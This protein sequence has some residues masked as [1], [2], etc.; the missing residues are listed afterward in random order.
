[1]GRAERGAAAGSADEWLLASVLDA[2]ADGIL[3]VDREGRTVLANKRFAELWRIPEELL[4]SRNDDAM[5]AFVLDQLA[6]PDAFLAKVRELYATHD[7]GVDVL[8]F[9]DGRVYERYS[10]PRLVGADVVGL[11][12]R[13][14][15]HHMIRALESVQLLEH[16]ALSA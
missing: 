11:N 9:R 7:S 10:R 14:G 3:V 6:D 4:Q 2:T 16:A 1:M 13:L 5:L 12:C 15:P 8:V